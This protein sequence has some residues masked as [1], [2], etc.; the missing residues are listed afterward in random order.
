MSAF[1]VGKSLVTP[2][3]PA[4]SGAVANSPRCSGAVA[5]SPRFSRGERGERAAP[6]T[7]VRPYKRMKCRRPALP[8]LKGP[9]PGGG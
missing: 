4:H 9:K 8:F 6:C 1:G 5:N 7:V 2:R 3:H